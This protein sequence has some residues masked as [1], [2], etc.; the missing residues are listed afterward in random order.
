M[1]KIAALIRL[2]RPHQWIKNS[3]VLVGLIFA[4]AWTQINVVEQVLCAM[5]A[6]C[7]MSSAVYIYNDISDRATDRLHP[8]KKHRPIANNDISCI[9]AIILSALLFCFAAFLGWSV[10][11]V[12]LII[13]LSYVLLNI[14]YTHVLKNIVIIDVFAIATGFMLRILAG[15]IGVGIIPSQWLMFC[16]LMITLFLGFTKRRA[17]NIAIQQQS[18]IRP[19]LKNYNAIFLDKM[20]SITASCSIIGYGLYT[21]SPD[22]THFHHTANLIYTIPFVIY[23]IFRYLYLLHNAVQRVGEDTAKDLLLDK[24]LFFTVIGW[25]VVVVLLIR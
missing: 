18:I 10:S 21:M 17:E 11:L 20:I 24:H 13:L 15:T 23:G 14:T 22:T 16:G 8:Q 1:S 3:F 12:V 2:L 9:T 4:H 6:F 19:V 5:L 25:F 7:L